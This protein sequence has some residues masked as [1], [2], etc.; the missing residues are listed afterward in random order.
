MKKTP[1]IIIAFFVCA[2][3]YAENS[4]NFSASLTTGSMDTNIAGP[5]VNLWYA[6]PTSTTH[7]NVT[8]DMGDINLVVGDDSTVNLGASNFAT[9]SNNWQSGDTFNTSTNTSYLDDKSINIDTLDTLANASGGSFTDTISG[10][11]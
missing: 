1:R 11:T 5:R 4:N 6:M 2:A 7:A 8:T 10:L 9:S 3:S